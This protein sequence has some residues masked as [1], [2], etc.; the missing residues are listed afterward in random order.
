MKVKRK[1]NRFGCYDYTLVD[2]DNALEIMYA[3]N[4]DLYFMLSQNGKFFHDENVT[5][6]F[7]ITKEDF[8]VFSLFDCL[9]KEVVA[10]EVF[11]DYDNDFKNSFLYKN[12]VSKKKEVNWISDDDREEVADRLSFFKVDD[13]TYRLLFYRN[14]KPLDFGFKSSYNISVRFRNS[15]S[16]YSP[17]N[18]PFMRFYQ[19]LQEVDPNYH[20]VHIEELVYIK[21]LNR[22]I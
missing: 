9:Y 19:R 7:D 3:G 22:N 8:Q 14:D 18:V 13:D 4:L 10:G 21:K 17:F 16:R 6:S 11:E 12:L 2:K 20:Q 15:G 5:L 1:E